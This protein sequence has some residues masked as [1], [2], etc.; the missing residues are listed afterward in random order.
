MEKLDSEFRHAL[1]TA[2]RHAISHIETLDQSSVAAS[3]DVETLRSRLAR[4]LNDVAVPADQVIDDLAR[5]VEG[6][7]IGSAG[8]RFF[9]WVI[10][11]VLPA[12]LAADWM[13]SA[14]QQNAAL[15][16]TSPAAA[17]RRGRGGL[18]EGSP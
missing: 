15:Y 1:D 17:V 14:W 4:Q 9:G 11:G 16:A 18:A 6:G 3:V 13:T 2:V 8:G 5:D 10:G 12:G 7:L